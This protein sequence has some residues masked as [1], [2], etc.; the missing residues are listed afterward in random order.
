[1][2]AHVII[3]CASGLHHFCTR[4]HPFSLTCAPRARGSCFFLSSTFR[5]LRLCALSYGG[6]VSARMSV[7][8][9]GSAK[10][11]LLAALEPSA[12]AAAAAPAAG[13][14]CRRKLD[15]GAH[16]ILSLL[17][18]RCR[19]GPEGGRG[20]GLMSEGLGLGVLVHGAVHDVLV[21]QLLSLAAV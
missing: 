1:M 16:E 2:C 3:M 13:A 6:D 10:S 17:S 4:A 8:V 11:A 20:E 14:T 5:S 9:A 21:H 12:S 18:R 7:Q 19:S 15:Q